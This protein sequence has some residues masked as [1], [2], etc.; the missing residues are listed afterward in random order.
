MHAQYTRWNNNSLVNSFVDLSNR[1]MFRDYESVLARRNHDCNCSTPIAQCSVRMNKLPPLDLLA[2]TLLNYSD[3]PRGQGDSAI[4]GY[5]FAGQQV[6][7]LR[8]SIDYLRWS[9]RIVQ[10]IVHR[11]A[12]R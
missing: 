12:I 9:S 10:Q 3:A 8:Q 7:S 5:H 4:L 1:L 6:L 11:M 2:E